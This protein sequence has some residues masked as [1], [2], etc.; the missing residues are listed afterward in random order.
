MSV[1][2]MKAGEKMKKYFI[3]KNTNQQIVN[4]YPVILK[5]GKELIEYLEN[6]TKKDTH[7]IVYGEPSKSFIYYNINGDLIKGDFTPIE[8]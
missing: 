1:L 7:I 5:D 4:N 6:F 8:E 3:L 2:E